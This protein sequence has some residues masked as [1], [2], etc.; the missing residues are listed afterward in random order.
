MDRSNT[1]AAGGTAPDFTLP[2]EC[3]RP[4]SLDSLIEDQ[5]VALLFFPSVWG[6]MCSVEMSTFRDMFSE[7]ERTGGRMI[8][9]STNSPMSHAAWCDHM[10]LPFHILSDF[11]GKVS[12][13]YGILCGDEGYLKGRC[14]RAIFIVDQKKRLRFVWVADDP[15]YEPDYDLVIRSLAEAA[16]RSAP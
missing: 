14:T 15:S 1:L 6:M 5:P 7:V 10:R 11:D 8:A 3:S 12:N 16:G 13:R 4:V 9:V 2:D